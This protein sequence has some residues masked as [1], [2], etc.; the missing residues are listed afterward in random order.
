MYSSKA[1]I[2]NIV[3]KKDFN[4]SSNSNR[5]LVPGS[6]NDEQKSV[7]KKSD[8]GKRKLVTQK[9]HHNE[10]LQIS[11]AQNISNINNIVVNANFN[12]GLTSN[13]TILMKEKKLSSG[14]VTK[15]DKPQKSTN[16]T[17]NNYN[18]NKTDYYGLIRVNLNQSSIK[19]DSNK[20]LKG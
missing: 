15:F 1:A 9:S 2:S 11:T 4:T 7:S 20:K 17:T 6:V 5:G 19:K 3:D 14:A 10:P 8:D 18:S 12:C 16:N 13:S